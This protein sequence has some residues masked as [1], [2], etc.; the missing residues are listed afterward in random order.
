MTSAGSARLAGHD[1]MWFVARDI[2][3]EHPDTADQTARMLARMG[4]SRAAGSA[5]AGRTGAV[6]AP[7]LLPTGRR[8]RPWRAWSPG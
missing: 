2:A 3:F 4:I 7:R 5:N 1:R 8:L 6:A